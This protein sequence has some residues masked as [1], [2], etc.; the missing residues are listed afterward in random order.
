M[1][2][3]FKFTK[4]L[5]GLGWKPFIVTIDPSYQGKQDGSLAG[6]IPIEA[7]IHRTG[8]FQPIKALE[9]QL[10]N[11]GST[12]NGTG[13]VQGQSGMRNEA[14]GGVRNTRAYSILRRL[15]EGFRTDGDYFGWIVPGIA[16]GEKTIRSHEIS[17]IFSSSPPVSSHLI[18]S[19]LKKRH[20]IPW[21]MDLRDPWVEAA[22]GNRC[23][24]AIH[25]LLEGRCVASSDRTVV[26]NDYVK[27]L[28]EKKY[29]RNVLQKISVI[30][31]GFDPEDFQGT[32]NEDGVAKR[33]EKTIFS[34]VG[35][36]Y[37][38]KR[39]PICFLQAMANL[40]N[41]DVVPRERIEIRLIG[42]G[43]YADSNEFVDFMNNSPDLA[44]VIVLKPRLPHGESIREM[45]NADVLLLFQNHEDLRYQ[46]PAKLFEYARTN[47]LIMAF[48]PE[49]ATRQ[50]VMA[51]ELGMVVDPADIGEIETAI[52]RALG[53]PHEERK[54]RNTEMYSRP[55]QAA[56]LAEIL[57]SLTAG[58]GKGK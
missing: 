6:M 33:S 45:L 51:H 9:S 24:K 30:M 52:L 55:A 8:L 4:Y 49:G 54:R 35:E 21:V 58:R 34:H 22:T 3:N 36:F 40:L 28:F 39:T 38:G 31:N 50:V 13:P 15:R 7:S 2:R 26:N 23:L 19:Y 32:P 5:P 48:C 27:I 37:E 53:S 41:R 1:L 11:L 47:A 42:A 17:V 20:G 25:R 43:E 14:A 57:D 56:Q 16:A 29:G 18:A 46:I 10:R 12:R 44:D